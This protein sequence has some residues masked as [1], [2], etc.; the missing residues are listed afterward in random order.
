MGPPYKC[1]ICGK[2]NFRTLPDLKKHVAIHKILCDICGESFYRKKNLNVHKRHVHDSVPWLAS[3][4][5]GSFNTEPEFSGQHFDVFKTKVRLTRLGL[6]ENSYSVKFKNLNNDVNDTITTRLDYLKKLLYQIIKGFKKQMSPADTSQL[7]LYGS[8]ENIKAAFSTPFLCKNDF[9]YAYITNRVTQLL[10]SNENFLVNNEMFIDI[11]IVKSAGGALMGMNKA[12]NTLAFLKRKRSVMTNECDD[13]L[14]Y[15]RAVLL[16]YYHHR[17][18]NKT[19]T[20]K[21]W[22]KVSKPYNSFVKKKAEMLQMTAGLSKNT[23]VS[24]KDT[25]KFEKCFKNFQI[26]VYWISNGETKILHSGKNIDSPALNVLYHTN[27]YYPI[28][29]LKAFKGIKHSC[30]YCGH[31]S[32]SRQLYQHVCKAKCF[33]CHGINNH[34]CHTTDRDNNVS[35]S[36]QECHQDFYS[37]ICYNQHK[38]K[39]Y[40][41]KDKKCARYL[42]A[43]Y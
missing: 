40:T 35:H 39:L 17:Y 25:R 30:E 10:N 21:S 24:I 13:N 8:P 33:L 5:G 36:C 6:T 29:N 41:K 28:I 7:I 23:Q 11:K 9:N 4:I 3:Q 19:I 16:A 15:A 31:T 14:C 26:N 34:P 43:L 20:K 37:E 1:N 42:Q 32:K 27:H 22:Y 18:K 12:P 2:K 38:I